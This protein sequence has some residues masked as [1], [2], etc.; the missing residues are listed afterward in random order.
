MLSEKQKILVSL[1]PPALSLLFAVGMFVVA[2]STTEP[3]REK[4]ESEYRSKKNLDDLN[5]IMRTHNNSSGRTNDYGGK[6]HRRKN[7]DVSNYFFLMVAFFLAPMGFLAAGKAL[8]LINFSEKT[9]FLT[10][11]IERNLVTAAVAICLLSVATL[12][13]YIGL[14]KLGFLP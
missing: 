4:R 1:I 14:L 13:G 3:L 5:E 8:G 10:N 12:C 2:Y 11:G 6:Q 7:N 9:I